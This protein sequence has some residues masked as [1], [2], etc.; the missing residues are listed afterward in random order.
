[1]DGD[2]ATI[3]VLIASRTWLH[4]DGSKAK[5]KE[6]RSKKRAAHLAHC[7][8]AL[9][10]SW[11]CNPRP[12]SGGGGGCTN[13][14]TACCVGRTKRQ[15]SKPKQTVAGTFQP[16]DFLRGRPPPSPNFVSRY[17]YEYRYPGHIL[18]QYT[19]HVSTGTTGIVIPGI[20]CIVLALLV[21]SCV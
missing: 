10:V 21:S 20:I 9:P 18:V 5:A 8:H 6:V 11:A 14:N 3:S 2:V 12:E 1:M 4:L 13:Y 16:C 19:W 7:A 15:S 17:V